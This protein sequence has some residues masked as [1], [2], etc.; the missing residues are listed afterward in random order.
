MFNGFPDKSVAVISGNASTK[1]IPFYDADGKLFDLA[2]FNYDSATDVLSAGAINLGDTTLSDYK[3][4]TWVPTVTA[5]AGAI[6]TYTL[7]SARYTR[8]GPLVAFRISIYLNNKGSASGN[9]YI[10][11]PYANYSDSRGHFRGRE[12]WA[13][14]VLLWGDIGSSSSTLSLYRE[15]GG[16]L[17]TNGYGF[18]MTGVY[19]MDA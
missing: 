5:G 11:L 18:D 2:A 12:D 3:S 10:S 6:T 16:S 9:M 13:T 8:I 7:Y 14:G 17:W 1:R 19:W 15:D 4:S